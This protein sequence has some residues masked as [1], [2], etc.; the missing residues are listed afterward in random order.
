ML[1]VH[2]AALSARPSLKGPLGRRDPI[3]LPL[4]DFI[5]EAHEP[6]T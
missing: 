4:S 5:G 1:C 3:F 6:S 2:K